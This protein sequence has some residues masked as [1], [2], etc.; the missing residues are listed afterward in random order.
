MDTTQV[1]S[2]AKKLQEES[3]TYA[4]FHSIITGVNRSW[5]YGGF[6][7]PDGTFWR[8]REPNAVIVVDGRQSTKGEANIGKNNNKKKSKKN[9]V[10]VNIKIYNKEFPLCESVLA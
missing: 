2:M 5:E 8:Y 6:P 4:G 10:N 1:N 3:I 7:L 9:Q